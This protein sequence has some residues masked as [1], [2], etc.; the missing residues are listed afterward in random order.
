VNHKFQVDIPF[1][2]P[3]SS[4]TLEAELLNAWCEENCHGRWNYVGGILPVGSVTDPTGAYLIWRFRFD[5]ERDAALFKMW[6][7]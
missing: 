3:L 5:Q 6:W 7:Q 1:S 2:T 4:G